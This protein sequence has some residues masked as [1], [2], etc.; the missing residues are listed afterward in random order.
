MNTRCLAAALATTSLLVGCM[1]NLN[2]RSVGLG[3]TPPP[4]PRPS[5]G[6]SSDVATASASSSA[7]ATVAT[8]APSRNDA[9][10]VATA[11]PSRNDAAPVSTATA[12]ASSAAT[13]RPPLSTCR[14]QQWSDAWPYSDRPADPWL[15][16]VDGRPARVAVNARHKGMPPQTSAVCDAAHDHCLRDCTWLVTQPNGGADPLARAFHLNTDGEF[17][18]AFEDTYH[19]QPGFVAYRTVPVTRAT[20]RVGALVMAV[21][22]PAQDGGRVDSAAWALRTRWNVGTVASIDWDGGTLRLEGHREPY[23]LSAARLAVLRS[24]DGGKVETIPGVDA[25]APSVADVIAPRRGAVGSDP[26]AA[27]GGDGQPLASADAS[28]MTGFHE[29]CSR[30]DHCLRPWVWFVDGATDPVPARW[31]GSQFVNADEA[32]APLRRPGVAYRTKAA[33]AA[34]LAPGQRVLLYYG[35]TPPTSE[36]EAH[37]RQ[38]WSFAEVAEVDPGRGTFTDGGGQRRPIALA[39]VLVL[40]WIAGDR[41]A[42]VE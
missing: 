13:G 20:L 18:D 12:A 19:P 9:A 22:A 39:R 33:T 24:V 41:A 31:T 26:W 21:P 15:A 38:H 23:F 1:A 7:A 27:V 34:D 11:P 40:Y 2:G 35:S 16:V 32:D 28:A 25:R 6:A 14:P 5:G 37:T 36:V 10:P 8:A 30:R 4:G 29:D 3:G 17:V 42:K